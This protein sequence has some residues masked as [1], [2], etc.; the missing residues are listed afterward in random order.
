MRHPSLLRFCW[1]FV[2]ILC[3]NTL[4]Y[5]Q[6]KY[7]LSVKGLSARVEALRD[8]WGVNHIYAANQHDLFFAQG[9]C[10]AKDRLFQFEIWRRQATGTMAAILGERELQRDISARLF[11]F[12]GDM[13]KELSHYHAQGAAIITAFTEG[14]NAYVKEANKHPEKLPVEFRLLNIRPG[15]WTPEVVISRHQGILGNVAEELDY[16]MATVAIGEK[17][18]KELLW[19]HPGDPDMKMDSTIRGELLT[20]EILS[21]YNAFKKDV[22][23]TAADI[24]TTSRTNKRLPGDHVHNSGKNLAMTPGAETEGSNNWVISGSR[25]ASGYPMLASDPH[26]KISLPS[27]RYIV[28]LSAPGWNV[29]GGGE[30]A[31]PGVAIGHNDHG[32]WGITVHQTDAED[33]YVYDINPQK[34]DQYRYQGHWIDMKEITETI[35]IKGATSRTVTLRYTQHG[36]VTY[37][38]SLHH[39]AYAVRAAWLEPGAAPYLS[40]LRMDQAKDWEMFREA[41]SY[42]RIPSL[43][44]IWADKK[45]NTGWQVIG[46]IPVRKKFS[47]LVPVPGDGRYEWAGYLPVKERPHLSNPSKGYWATANENLIPADF[48]YPEAMGFTWPD[49]YRA[50]RIEEVL[51]ARTNMDM[52]GM[53]DLQTD[54]VSLPAR[55]LVLLLQRVNVADK[56]GEEARQALLQWDLVMGRNSIGAAIYN[57]WERELM[58]QA[59]QQFIPASVSGLVTIQTTRLIEWLQHPDEMFGKEPAKGRDH[60]LQQTFDTAIA[61]LKRQLGD[62]LSSWQ[63]G[64]EKYKHITFTHP[65]SEWVSEEWKLQLNTTPQPRAG[66]GHTVGATG[67]MDNQ[68]NGASFRYITDIRDWDETLMINA[69]GQSGN[70]ESPWYKNLVEMWARDEYFPAYFSKEKI[71][72]VT[73]EHTTLDPVK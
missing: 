62:Q 42:S 73:A 4:P 53:K 57:K 1:L 35:P 39:K 12:R 61:K 18:L 37:I 30:P 72:K 32:A 27:L 36:P 2:L 59:Q 71:R 28:H 43:N 29:M 64:Q 48:R 21:L 34:K 45:G 58:Q 23:F 6:D 66:Y 9:Y 55:E 3:C 38:D 63:Y 67:N 22:L 5:A 56:L 31:I 69:P 41:C 10:A 19:L 11:K 33:L 60:F 25:T 46:I 17:K 65:L 54:Y 8:Q 13:N 26:R 40:S 24:V 16:G 50:R 20:R 14:V 51:K 70:P 15:A 47:G 44:M 49:A 52:K 68:G 7:H